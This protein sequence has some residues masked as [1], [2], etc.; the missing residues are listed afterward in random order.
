MSRPFSSL[1][2]VV[3]LVA[4]QSQPVA[5][6]PPKM[7]PALTPVRADAP[8]STP[9]PAEAPAV[10]PLPGEGERAFVS[11]DTG[12]VEV[13]LTG[14]SQVI[15]PAGVSWCSVDAR[16]QVVWFV[17]RSGLQ[18]FDLVDRRVHPI[19]AAELAELAIIIDWGTEQLGGE[20]RL[21]FDVGVAI[22]MASAPSIKT[23]MG[24][25]GDR[26]VYCFEEDGKTPTEA[27]ARSQQRATALRLV[28][29]VYLAAIAGRGANRSL[30]TPPPMPPPPPSR[31]PVVR[32]KQCEVEPKDCGSLIAIPSSP[33]W[34]VVTGN[35]SGDYYHED[36]ELWDPRTGE[37]VR[38]AGDIVRSKD[39][40][41]TEST[42]DYAG[43]RVSNGMF[44]YAGAVFD[45]SRV[46]FAPTAT[47][48]APGSCGFTSGGW[49][50]KGPTG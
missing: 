42:G 12:L 7:P 15:A 21:Q 10:A 47:D 25:D 36:R 1:T 50:I 5:Q 46:V 23:V 13:A 8:A 30:W 48:G 27:L 6:D 17:T 32:R 31:T 28:D 34:L 49:R 41:P 37:F 2:F 45:D 38:R 33:L 29:P 19:L 43:L 39:A 18:A 20:D 40:A 26:A 24:C 14:G 4:C 16:A 11:D 22:G 9:A 44:T 35:S 3:A